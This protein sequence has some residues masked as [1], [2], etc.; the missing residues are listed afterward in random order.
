[1][2]R[3]S[4]D[5]KTAERSDRLEGDVDNDYYDD[6]DRSAMFV[7]TAASLNTATHHISPSN[8]TAVDTTIA[9]KEEK[10]LIVNISTINY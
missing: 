4:S 7:V 9:G 1:M 2:V 6:T 10:K 3:R 5:V 8:V